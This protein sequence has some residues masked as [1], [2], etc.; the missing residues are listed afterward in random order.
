MHSSYAV[1]V[2]LYI[3][4]DDSAA[5][6][7]FLRPQIA[8]WRVVVDTADV[9]DEV[10]RETPLLFPFLSF[11]LFVIFVIAMPLLFNNFLVSLYCGQK[12]AL[13]HIVGS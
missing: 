3:L 12:K 9:D 8:L 4:Q 2:L 1:I 6:Q 10:I 13:I 5:P 7:V 11:A